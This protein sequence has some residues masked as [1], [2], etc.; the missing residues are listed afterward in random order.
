MRLAASILLAASLS[1]CV[2]VPRP[3]AAAEDVFRNASGEAIELPAE[4][5]WAR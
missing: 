2:L 3:D 1:G 5:E 4:W